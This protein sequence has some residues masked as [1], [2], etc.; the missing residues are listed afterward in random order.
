MRWVSRR[1]QLQWSVGEG[2]RVWLSLRNDK[3]EKKL[4]LLYQVHEQLETARAW[5]CFISSPHNLRI[6]D[7]W[8]RNAL[9]MHWNCTEVAFW[10]KNSTSE[11]LTTDMDS[12][13]GTQQIGALYMS[14]NTTRI[15]SDRFSGP[16]LNWA[17]SQLCLFPKSSKESQGVMEL[18]ESDRSVEDEQGCFKWKM[19]FE[20]YRGDRALWS[21]WAVRSGF[22]RTEYIEGEDNQEDSITYNSEQVECES[23]GCLCY[24]TCIHLT[25]PCIVKSLSS[26]IFIMISACSM[27]CL[28]KLTIDLTIC[29]EELIV[30]LVYWPW[31][32]Y[33]A[34]NSVKL[35]CKRLTCWTPPGNLYVHLV[36]LVDENGPLYSSSND[37]LRF[38]TGN[39]FLHSLKFFLTDFPSISGHWNVWLSWIILANGLLSHSILLHLPLLRL[40]NHLYTFLRSCDQT[41]QKL[42]KIIILSWIQEHSNPSWADLFI[43]DGSMRDKPYQKTKILRDR[44]FDGDQWIIVISCKVFC[45]LALRQTNLIS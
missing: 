29:F 20:R 8:T 19:I 44:L 27:T 31:A 21:M 28:C 33:Q 9:E 1:K 32:P 41:W 7:F 5:Y 15:Y 25:I 43:I 34:Q 17:F 23:C 22:L 6:Q 16:Y 11:T 40:L 10:T 37:G 2:W 24:P 13:Q 30:L 45:M 26:S 4:V 42:W 12:K 35:L 36:W 39:L 3:A 14:L 38:E 18:I